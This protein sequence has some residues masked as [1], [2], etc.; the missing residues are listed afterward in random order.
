MK[1]SR[2][3]SRWRGSAR[4]MPREQSERAPKQGFDDSE[5]DKAT[6][7]TSIRQPPRARSIRLRAV[8]LPRFVAPDFLLPSREPS[9]HV[10]VIAAFGIGDGEQKSL[11]AVEKAQAQHVG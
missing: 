5:N 1:A 9:L 8:P 11:G 6:G 4:P 3:A 10:A 7:S 2:S